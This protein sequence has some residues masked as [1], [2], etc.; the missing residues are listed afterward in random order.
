MSEGADAAANASTVYVMGA[1]DTFNGNYSN[2]NDIDWIRI[3]LVAGQSYTFT[4]DGLGAVDAYLRLYDSTGTMV[5]FNDD[6]AGNLDSRISFNATTS[7][8]YYLEAA[9]YE[10]QNGGTGLIGSYVLS[11][12]QFVETR[13][14]WT[15]AEMADQLIN[16]YWQFNGLSARHFDIAAGGTITF[17]LGALTETM[18]ALAIAAM[19]AWT[20]TTGIVFVQIAGAAMINFQMHE[21]GAFSDSN[22]GGGFILDSIV[23]VD[24]AWLDFSGTTLN[25]YTF[26]TYV[27]EIGHAIGL[28]HA[29]N[30]NGNATYGI[31]NNAL[32]DSWQL[33]IMSYFD[34]Q[35]NTYINDTR[36]Y[37]LTPM[38]ADILAMQ[39]MYGSVGIR[40]GNTTYGENSNAG[41][42]YAQ[43]SVFNTDGDE[44]NT[45]AITI[46]DTGGFD[47]L[48]FQSDTQNQRI[49]MRAGT[50]SDVYGDIGTL[51]IALGTAIERVLAGSGNDSI[52]GNSVANT[53]LSNNG[54]DTVFGGDGN[55]YIGGGAGNDLLNG[56]TGNDTVFAGFGVDTVNGGDGNDSIYGAGGTN[57]L[58]GDGGNDQI[59]TSAAGDFVGGGDGNDTVRGAGGNDTIY[60]GTGNDNIG[61]GAG[62][63]LIYGSAGSNIIYAGLGNDTVQGGTGADTIYGSAGRNRLFGNDGN[64]VIYTSAAGDLAAGGS[65]NDSVYGSTGN[66]TIYAGLGNDFIGGGAGNDLIVAGAGVNRIYGGT[67]NDTMVAGTGRDVMTGGPGADVFV[68]NSAAHIGIGAGRDVITDFTSGVDDID[69]RGLGQTFNGTAGLI[70]AGTASF[71]YVA[72]SG[73]LIGD[74]NGDGTADW[75]LELSG[76]PTINAGDFLL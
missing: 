15:P 31:D 44:D 24:Q 17:N 57:R 14:V 42:L 22:T 39:Q 9:Q 30:Y 66:D 75:V 35:D 74:Q 5:A 6:G 41:S 73:L 50:Y 60:A 61:G 40:T 18:Q 8:T 21:S 49:D 3:E 37:L 53:I 64:D 1:G 63:D 65:G 47:T 33:T 13:T 56:G 52:T 51:A 4:L 12:E 43:F 11:A 71:Y 7:G 23:N 70:G 19:D 38:I 16:G 32:N 27:H 76:A 59:F 54:N 2:G 46:V 45:V 36:A 68:F 58:L 29:G 69:L 67:G 20:Q 48:D 26:Q 10:N 28:G 72:A 55:D 34:Q 62:N 25:S